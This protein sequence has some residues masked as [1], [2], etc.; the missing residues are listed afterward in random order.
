MVRIDCDGRHAKRNLDSSFGKSGWGIRPQGLKP[1]GFLESDAQQKAHPEPVQ[2]RGRASRTRAVTWKSGASALR[3]APKQE[4]G[5]SPRIAHLQGGRVS[6]IRDAD[7]KLGI[8]LH[9]R[10]R[11]AAP[12][13]TPA[14]PAAITRTVARH[15]AAAEAARRSVAQVDDSG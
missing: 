11:L 15:D 5:F 6:L 3:K 2:H 7:S 8:A 12:A 10:S 4:P 13:R 14:T 9:V 1:A